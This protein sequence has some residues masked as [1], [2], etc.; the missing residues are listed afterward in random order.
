[1][2]GDF[3]DLTAFVL[4]AVRA[5]AVGEL[6]LVAVGAFGQ[7]HFFEGI[8]RAALSCTRSGVSSFRIRHFYSLFF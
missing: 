4:A 5:D 7:A 8:V 2:F 1:L 3:D 6:L